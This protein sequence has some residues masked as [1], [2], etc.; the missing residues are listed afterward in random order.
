MRVTDRVIDRRVLLEAST[1]VQNGYRVTV[2]A[3]PYPADAKVPAITIWEGV[4]IHR[5]K[6]VNTMYYFKFQRCL[7]YI[8]RFCKRNL[9]LRAARFV[10]RRVFR[11]LEQFSAVRNRMFRRSS[12][13][14][15]IIGMLLLTPF[16]LFEYLKQIYQ[17]MFLQARENIASRSQKNVYDKVEMICEKEIPDICHAHDITTLEEMYNISKQHN[18]K[19]V[20]DS[21]ELYVEIRTLTSFQKENLTRL[22]ANLIKKTDLV[23]TINDSIAEELSHR[24][25]IPKPLILMNCTKSIDDV[26]PHACYY[27]HGKLHLDRSVDIFLYQGNLTPGR[28]LDVFVESARYLNKDNIKLVLLGNEGESGYRKE[29]LDIVKKYSLQDKI[30]FLEAASQEKLLYHTISAKAGVIPY[31]PV[32]LNTYYCTP[33]K[34]FEFITAHI[35]I[36]SNDLPELKKL[37][38]GNNI[39]IATDLSTPEKMAQAINEMHDNSEKYTQFKKNLI[40]VSKELCWENESSKLVKEYGLLF[41]G[42]EKC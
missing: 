20:Y 12:R 13:L 38:G 9:I 36:L 11:W 19:F 34:L 3:G 17:E 6:D 26:Q 22:E 37:V 18:S 33:N 21:H 28:G 5:L 14:A 32:D 4:Q 41:A 40:S 2:I 27:L 16:L 10:S 39:G 42:S 29:L 24:Y 7:K 15:T 35:P 8:H 1:L 30:I 25:D 31:G 23:I